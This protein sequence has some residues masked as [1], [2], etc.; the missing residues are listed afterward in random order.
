MNFCLIKLKCPHVLRQLAINKN[1]N[2]DTKAD[3]AIT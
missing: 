1:N 2:I 3:N